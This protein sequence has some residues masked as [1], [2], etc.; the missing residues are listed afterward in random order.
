MALLM[1]T[2]VVFMFPSH[3]S[4]FLHHFR[5]YVVSLSMDHKEYNA[6]WDTRHGLTWEPKFQVN[7]WYA[8]VELIKFLE[9]LLTYFLTSQFPITMESRCFN[10]P[11]LKIVFTFM[12]GLDDEHPI[13]KYYLAWGWTT[14]TCCSAV[15]I[16]WC[17]NIYLMWPCSPPLCSHLERRVVKLGTS[18]F[19]AYFWHA[20]YIVVTVLSSKWQIHNVANL[21]LICVHIFN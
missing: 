19:L 8:Y 2:T 15:S 16:E 17:E 4:H 20:Y 6:R 14:F 11:T 1:H 13:Y 5:K 21:W 12:L 18:T 9:I 3:Y 10:V 7:V